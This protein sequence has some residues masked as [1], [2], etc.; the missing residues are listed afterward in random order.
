MIRSSDRPWNSDSG[1]EGSSDTVSLSEDTE[2]VLINDLVDEI[3]VLKKIIH[4]LIQKDREKEQ[5]VKQLKDLL[6]CQWG[7]Q[8]LTPVLDFL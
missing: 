2:Q 3:K 8:C 5:Q 1:D 4:V 7:N 6:A